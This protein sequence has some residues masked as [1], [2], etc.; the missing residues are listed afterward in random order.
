MALLG[1]GL[2]PAM[3]DYGKRIITSLIYIS[4]NVFTLQDDCHDTVLN[5]IDRP[6]VSYRYN[7]ASE[8]YRAATLVI[9][10]MLSRYWSEPFNQ[11]SP[12]IFTAFTYAL[13][14]YDA[15]RYVI[16]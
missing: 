2:C 6:K 16:I 5:N 9:R 11:I 14:C 1:R 8:I 12:Y 10:A 15:F 3:N 7:F 4:V 13:A